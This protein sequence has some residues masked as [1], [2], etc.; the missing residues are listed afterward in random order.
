MSMRRN[1][2]VGLV[3]GTVVGTV[4]LLAACSSGSDDSQ[5]SQPEN[6]EPQMT[7]PVVAETT[8]PTTSIMPTTST[9]DTTPTTTVSS[10]GPI[11]PT[12]AEPST[13]GE[14][15]V[16]GPIQTGN[17]AAVITPPSF[18]VTTVGYVQE[19]YF[20]SGTASAYSSA[21]PLQPDG[22]WTVEPTAP[23]PYTTRILVRRPADPAAFSG[24]VNVEWL[25]VTA[26]FDASPDW[27]IAH[28]EMIRS[29]DAWVG[30]SAQT[31]GINGREGA[32]VPLALKIADPVRY[33]PLDHPGDSYSYDMFSQA[34]A[35]VR[36]QASMLLGGVQPEHLIA[37]GQS[38]SAFR[39]TTYVNAV[40]PI[41]NVYDGYLLHS[42]GARG[43]ALSEDPLAEVAAPDPAL[44]RTDL[45]V[46]VLQALSETDL[47]GDRL[48]FATARQPDT[49]FI[50]TWEMAGTSHQDLYGLG[51]GDADDGSGA[52]DTA[53]FAAMSV[54]VS[55]LYGGV[56]SCGAPINAGPLTYVMRSAVASLESWVVTGQPPA[57]MP[58]IEIDDAG[59]IVV[60]DRGIAI[61]G[62]RTPHVDV[63]IAR[64]SGLGQPESDNFCGLFGT[65]T[66][67]DAAA[68][69]LLY[70]DQD[71]FVTAW[72]ASVDSAVA[73]G[74]VM[75]AD[76]Q[77]L[78]D[79]AAAG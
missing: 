35:A 46:P 14:V 51:I 59:A 10:C 77:R 74:A 36:T 4:A 61:G 43:A 40:A 29:G 22:C 2:R 3:V 13:V 5:S 23:E 44:I 68:L 30:V 69:G 7:E 53:L 8:T 1:A 48:G 52:A 25:N 17:G 47:V 54:P 50:R 32:L 79:V 34:G 64:L 19:E 21:S 70:P 20:I 72:N 76:A 9:P 11:T 12:P 78:E 73:S 56:I 63:P 24:T 71:A 39:L 38:Q 37:M 41:A 27:T 49:D 67:F 65:T 18:D 15:T 62:I 6:T 75:A 66:P 42:R 33:E 45:G 55:D 57:S 31:V 58:Q 28:T 26:G 16:D 60:D